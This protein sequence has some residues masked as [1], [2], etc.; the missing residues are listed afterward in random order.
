MPLLKRHTLPSHLSPWP[1]W[2]PSSTLAASLMSSIASQQLSRSCRLS[3]SEESPYHQVLSSNV[4]KPG[5][6]CLPSDLRSICFQ[7]KA[8]TFG[9]S[10]S[11]AWLEL[12][13]TSM[14]LFS[15][16]VFKKPL[17]KALISASNEP[18]TNEHA[19]L[20]AHS[21][22]HKRLTS[23]TGHSNQ[24]LTACPSHVSLD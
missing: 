14:P 6:G 22:V 17:R 21:H 24:G 3:V 5:T 10:N 4:G 13:R 19:S 18:L 9:P 23:Q 8:T 1:P 12:L 16:A 11:Q 7:L 2:W 20:C 15:A